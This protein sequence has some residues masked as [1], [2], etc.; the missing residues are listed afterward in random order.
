LRIVSAAAI[1]SASRTLTIPDPGAAANFVLTEGAAF[2]I[3]PLV[4]FTGGIGTLHN[5]TV[6]G[7]GVV[8]CASGTY[9]P[10]G[11]GTTSNCSS[12]SWSLAKWIRIGSVVHVV[13]TIT[14][15]AGATSA[16]V[17]GF[18]IPIAS[19]FAAN[20]DAAGAACQNDDNNAGIIRSDATNNCVE[21]AY[22]AVSTSARA[23]RFSFSYEVI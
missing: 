4:R 5:G 13:G 11:A 3:T 23:W 1:A 9:T 18:T 2:S 19:D 15:T 12:I 7:A 14:L 10:T 21:L 22:T 17:K 20:S 16:V 8:S 6:T